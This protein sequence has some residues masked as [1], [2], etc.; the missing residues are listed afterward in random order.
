MTVT[1]F[2]KKLPA[3]YGNRRLFTT[4]A[5]ARHLS[6]SWARSINSRPTSYS[7]RS[8]LIILAHLCLD[9]PGGP[10]PSA[11]PTKTLNAT[12]LSP[13]CSTCHYSLVLLDVITGICGSEYRSCKS[14]L[15]HFLNFHFFIFY[16]PFL[17]V[18]VFP[19]YV[20]SGI[21]P[22]LTDFRHIRKTA[23]S[24]NYFHHARMSV[25]PS[26]LTGRIFIKLDVRVFF[27]NLSRRFKFH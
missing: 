5:T 25:R 11:F 12:L 17:F 27:E 1:P 6:L 7:W 13:L 24:D 2:V 20:N 23:K 21:F 4:L 19:K 22:T 9:L 15:C 26:A 10:F 14:S 18:R 8:I 16:S 3:F